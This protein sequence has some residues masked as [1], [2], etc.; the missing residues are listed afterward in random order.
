MKELINLNTA[1]KA[2]LTHLPGIGPA[3]AERIISVRPFSSMEDLL[4]ISG[5]SPGL[6]ERLDALVTLG[7][8][9][10]DRDVG[11]N[12]LES[13]A[14]VLVP[15]VIEEDQLSGIE[16]L[17]EEL[18]ESLEEPILQGESSFQV[19]ERES[20]KT[21]VPEKSKSITWGKLILVSTI[22]SFAV[23]VLAVLLSLGIIGSI[24]GG[25][26][27]ATTYQTQKIQGQVDSLKTEID[28]LA[29]DIDGLRTRVDNLDSLSG[30]IGELET[31][32]EKLSL[33]FGN[34][35]D[36]YQEILTKVTDLSDA[37]NRFTTFLDG[38]AD[39]IDS[40]AVQP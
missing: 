3:L 17:G 12:N 6:L 40:I 32:T 14:E 2:D 31:S 33:E 7:K 9:E 19:E 37:V 26:S 20:R 30:R 18:E 38:L 1:E 25:L 10:T 11:L 15:D 21:S 36:S 24:N 13:T 27:F 23:L 34:I 28:V 4:Q 5:I 8:D 29:G 22:W 16:E 35:D 39:L